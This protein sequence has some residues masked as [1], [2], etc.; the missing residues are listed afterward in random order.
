MN[1]KAESGVGVMLSRLQHLEF[2]TRDGRKKNSLSHWLLR[3][4][5][6]LVSAWASQIYPYIYKYNIIYSRD[7]DGEAAQTE[8]REY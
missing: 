8:T 1:N 6:W 7:L 2:E 5:C 4:C 3:E